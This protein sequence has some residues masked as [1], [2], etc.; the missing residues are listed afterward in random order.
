MTPT[1]KAAMEQAL[2]ALEYIDSNYMSL[3]KLGNE[4][5]TALRELLEQ[6]EQGHDHALEQALTRL[7][8][9]YT[10]LEA[11][12]VTQPADLN[13]NCKSVQAR[14]AAQWG[15]VRPSTWVGL[16]DEDIYKMTILMGFNPEWKPEVEMVYTVVRNLE[17]KLKEKNG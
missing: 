15:Y 10:E 12:V 5:S 17:A 14:L 7:Q 13:L 11:K 3:P 4:A 9:R 16:T 1:Q 6:P 2:E 8:K